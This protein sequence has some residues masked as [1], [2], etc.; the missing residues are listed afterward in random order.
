MRRP[1]PSL[2]GKAATDSRY[3]LSAAQSDSTR[4]GSPVGSLSV[5]SVP[6]SPPI[7]HL[8]AQDDPR[9]RRLLYLYAHQAVK[10]WPH[11]GLP[12]HGLFLDG[13]DGHSRQISKHHDMPNYGNDHK[14]AAKEQSP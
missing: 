11:R 2:T 13:I 1:T 10:D 12:W 14:Q 6:L 5:R 8:Y 7:S 9:A 3:S 4:V